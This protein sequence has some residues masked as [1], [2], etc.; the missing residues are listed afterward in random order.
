MIEGRRVLAVVPAR[1]G[2]KGIPRK[3]LR[4]V[5][6][7]SLV[8]HAG[9]AARAVA[10]IDRAVVSTDDDDIRDEALRAG[11]AAP[12]ARPAALSGD[13]VGDV[14]VLRHA[15]LATEAADGVR[16][17]VVLMLQPTSPLRAPADVRACLRELV[18]GGWDSV[19]TVSEAPLTYHPRKQLELRG[20]QLAYF[21]ADGAGVVARQ[22]LTPTFVR[23]GACYAL[24]RACLEEQRRLLGARAGY[25][26]LEGEHVSIDTEDDLRRV[27]AILRARGG[28]A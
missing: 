11:L 28:P 25:L 16:Y 5:A 24:T 26:Q 27:D 3:N 23:N 10:E 20:G 4:C 19:W 8:A 9:A 6:G 14:E 18:D 21:A 13:A 1:G 15:L 7:A 2:S 22:Q 12:F 17:E